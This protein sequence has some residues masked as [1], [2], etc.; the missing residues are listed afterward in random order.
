MSAA[1]KVLNKS[2]GKLVDEVQ[3]VVLDRVEAFLKEKNIDVADFEDFRK[4]VKT[5]LTSQYTVS[6]SKKPQERKKRAPSEYNT[7][8]GSKIK[9]LKEANSDKDG[10]ELMKMAIEAWKSRPAASK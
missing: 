1:L 3:S 8:I 6:E 10:K 5:E 7:F 9:E 2:V 4:T